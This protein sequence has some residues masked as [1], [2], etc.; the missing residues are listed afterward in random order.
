MGS[1]WTANLPGRTGRG[2]RLP[3]V[4]RMATSRPDRRVSMR[5]TTP[6]RSASLGSSMS[7][8]STWS[9]RR[10]A[11]H[12][13][14]S[15][16][17]PEA[18]RRARRGR[19][20]CRAT[21]PVLGSVLE[22]D[23]RGTSGG[24][25]STAARALRSRAPRGQPGSQKGP[26][27]H[28]LGR[29]GDALVLQ[30]LAGLDVGSVVPRS[31]WRLFRVVVSPQICADGDL[32]TRRVRRASPSPLSQSSSRNGSARCGM[33]NPFERRRQPA[34]SVRPAGCLHRTPVCDHTG[35]IF[36]ET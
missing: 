25:A 8:T 11:F 7:W 1:K 6:A 30:R 5:V 27:V 28:G 12:W 10:S 14:F 29:P 9:P 33:S 24:S 19:T 31:A 17:P 32:A 16:T 21:I 36:L 23:H 13:N 2:V 34:K 22:S 3:V 20:G 35:K 15:I 18:L 26:A 4:Y